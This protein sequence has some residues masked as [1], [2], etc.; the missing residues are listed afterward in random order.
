MKNASSEVHCKQ[1]K[2]IKGS[3][4]DFVACLLA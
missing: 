3:T 4:P 2:Q 1:Y